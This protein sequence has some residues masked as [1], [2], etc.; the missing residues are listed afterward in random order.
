MSI[1]SFG[2]RAD[3]SRL[4][5]APVPS[6]IQSGEPVIVLSSHGAPQKN[7]TVLFVGTT[8]FAAGNWIGVSLDHP[9]GE[10]RS[11]LSFGRIAHFLF[12]FKFRKH[13]NINFD[14]N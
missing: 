9:E 10:N 7:G 4:N 3:L 11:R 13:E 14:I 12:N 1:C 5:D 8:D 2:S 6:W